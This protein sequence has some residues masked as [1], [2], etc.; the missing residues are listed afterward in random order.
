MASRWFGRCVLGGVFV[1][2]GWL[3]YGCGSSDR[4]DSRPG[5]GGSDVGGSGSG[6]VGGDERDAQ[7][8]A[9]ASAG[10]TTIGGGG[11]LAGGG[12]AGAAHGGAGGEGEP[13]GGGA[14]SGAVGGQGGEGGGSTA[15]PFAGDCGAVS[16]L[17]NCGFETPVAAAGS[18]VLLS[19]GQQL[20]GWTVVGA[21]GNVGTLSATF[22]D[23]GLAWPAQ[24]QS[25]TLD[26]TGN[27][28]VATGVSQ[29]V[30]TE[31]GV[32]YQLSFW[33]GNMSH[34]GIYGTSSTVI[35]QLENQEILRVTNTDGAGTTSLA[36]RQFSVTFI[37]TSASSTLS[38]VNGDSAGDNS[39]II[40][41][42]VLRKL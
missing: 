39:N 1:G 29:A 33:S 13:S 2:A 6:G 10:S 19:V 38:F 25:Q 14:G 30:V 41:N 35:V 40:D 5:D 7:A 36:W 32:E 34:T 12:S 28:T 8:G 15:P 3:A 16:L 4:H 20:D 22:T 37:A 24:E 31:V 27:T 42:V 21:S 9:G 11:G 26:L 23:A 18:F 17:A